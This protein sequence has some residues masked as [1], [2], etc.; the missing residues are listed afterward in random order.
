MRKY[1]LFIAVMLIGLPASPQRAFRSKE[2]AVGEGWAGNSINTVVFR[3]NS[4]CSHGNLQFIAYYNNEGDVVLGKR[5]INSSKWELVTT[6]FKGNI[7]D[8]HN[9]ISIIADGD[10]YLHMAWD[11]HN[12]TLHYSRS[13]KPGSLE[14]GDEMPMTGSL[15]EKVTYPEFYTLPAG[16]LLF[17]YR[18][19]RSGRGNLVVNRYNVK[20]KKWHQL[21]QN[22]I[23]GEQ[24]RNAYWQAC[25][26][27]AGTVHLSWV[28]R[29]SPDVASNHDMG[30]AR[31]KD[32]GLHWE[33]SKGEIYSLPIK[34][35]TMEYAGR[36]P[37][38][39]E[40]INQTSMY[41]DG[42]G[43]PFIASYWRDKNDTLPQYHILYNI[44]QG[45]EI[46]NLGFR[47]TAFSLSG[48]GTKRIPISRPQLVV[49]N[50]NGK[51][52]ALLI[53]RDE[54]LGSK[55]T[56]AVADDIRS[57]DWKLETLADH[58]VG[59][60]EPAYDTE[61]WKRETRLDVFVQYTDQKD[62]E[63]KNAIPATRVSVLSVKVK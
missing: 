15:E 3:K 60:W 8:A 52:Q 5:K 31:S 49:Q 44:G 61:L 28:W 26:D 23:D 13:S 17:F 56:L 12:N 41:A 20:E 21:H 4:L 30:Y 16:D 63:G 10:G 36:I 2:V 32:G 22:L 11:H 18:D 29:E 47:R 27:A 42:Q 37:Q 57:A 9:S 59:S 58:S 50:R 6:R 39:S 40:L 33:N 53:F 45:W 34:E 48:A 25:V 55:P 35:A 62:S 1:H 51:Y 46:V 38:K 14:M 19:G 24:K 7:A 43:N 54:E